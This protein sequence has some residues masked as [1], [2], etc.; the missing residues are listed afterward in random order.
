MSDRRISTVLAR[1]QKHMVRDALAVVLLAVGLGLAAMMV[2]F[3]LPS[4]M[5]PESRAD[6]PTQAEQL[7]PA[8]ATA[9]QIA[10]IP[11]WQ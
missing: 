11:P 10:E 4:L 2:A 9:K 1:Q 3:H 7:S 6:E 5:P 8:K